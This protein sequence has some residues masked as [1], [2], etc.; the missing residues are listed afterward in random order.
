MGYIYKIVNLVNNKVYVG[1]TT[2]TLEERYRE[3]I[4]H[5]K[6]HD[7]D[8]SLYKAMNK[9]GYENFKISTLEEA[10]DNKLNEKEIY[11]IALYRSNQRRFGYNMTEGG[12]GI[13]SLPPEVESLRAAKISKALSGRKQPADL[14]EKRTAKLRGQKRTA[15]QRMRFSIAHKG[16]S[17]KGTPCSEEMKERLRKANLGK[18][19]SE[20]TK[21]KRRVSISK[22]K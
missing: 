8:N 19:Q 20:E 21:Q 7:R 17:H 6:S 14:I 22:L 9:Y 5:A 15:E 11:Y 3:H 1:Q 10:S 4:N 12:N 16:K 18:K 2:R 13:S